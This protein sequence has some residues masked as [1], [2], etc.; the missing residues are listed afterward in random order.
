MRLSAA[1]HPPC[2]RPSPSPASASAARVLHPAMSAAAS[3]G[4]ADAAALNAT[5]F[6][7]DAYLKKVLK[8]TRL[9]ELAGRQR[10]MLIEVGGLD[11][12]MQVCGGRA[13]V[14]RRVGRVRCLAAA[15]RAWHPAHQL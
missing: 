11:S 13:G 1:R 4:S 7:P 9:A 6:D 10:D 3:A 5:Y 2:C 14:G 12:D 8:E 15:R